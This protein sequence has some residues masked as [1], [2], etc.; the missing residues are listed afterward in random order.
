[1]R[2]KIRATQA[3]RRKGKIHF[4]VLFV[5]LVVLA[6]FIIRYA[7]TSSYFYVKDIKIKGLHKLSSQ[8]LLP[9]DLVPPRTCI[10]ELDMGRIHR[11]IQS[12]SW[13]RRVRVKKKLPSTLLIEIEER[14]PYACVRQANKFWQVD[15]EGV[16]LQETRAPNTHVVI[17]GVN[18]LEEEKILLKTLKALESSRSLNLKVKKIVVKRGNEGI[19]LILEKGTQ[20]VLGI[21]PNYN[22]LSYLPYIFQDA[23]R[24]GEK[25]NFVDLRFDNQIV[26]SSKARERLR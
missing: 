9:E 5:I 10:F 19:V 23:R 11:R 2:N 4:Y 12:N 14:V 25:F 21:S 13:V 20:V 26:V 15:R 8:Q 18:P 24:R 3:K 22:Y 17:A 7:L 1:M 6:I 16:L